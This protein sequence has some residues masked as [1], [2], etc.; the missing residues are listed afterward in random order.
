MIVPRRIVGQLGTVGIDKLLQ[1]RD[2]R[3]AAV[4][5]VDLDAHTHGLGN[6]CGIQPQLGRVLSQGCIPIVG[7]GNA[8]D[9][10]HDTDAATLE[11]VHHGLGHPGRDHVVQAGIG[12]VEHLERVDKA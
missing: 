9:R 11:I 4:L 6:G 2:V 3:G 1:G 5:V 10:E 7:I 12:Q 8:P